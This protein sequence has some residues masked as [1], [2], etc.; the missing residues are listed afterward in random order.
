MGIGAGLPSVARRSVTVRMLMTLTPT[1]PSA[2]RRR[3]ASR[4]EASVGRWSKRTMKDWSGRTQGWA[5]HDDTGSPSMG[6]IRGV[7]KE[8]R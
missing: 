7:S 5:R 4:S 8:N 1:S 6:W 3:M 2:L